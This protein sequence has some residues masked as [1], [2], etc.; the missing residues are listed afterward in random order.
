M[1][2]WKDELGREWAEAEHD[3]EVVPA[4]MHNARVVAIEREWDAFLRS[5]LCGAPLV[6]RRSALDAKDAFLKGDDD[7]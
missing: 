4:A 3:G 1:K 5:L 2:Y 6:V 7:A